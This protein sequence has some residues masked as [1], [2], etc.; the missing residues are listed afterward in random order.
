MRLK[1]RTLLKDKGRKPLP[2]ILLELIETAFVHRCIPLYYFTSFLYRKEVKNYLDYICDRESLQIHRA[3][4]RQD[5]LDILD[6][7]LL[8]HEHFSNKRIAMP[9]RLGYNL[10]KFWF[11][12]EASGT[13]DTEV[14]SADEFAALMRKLFKHSDCASIFAKPLR[15]GGGS[16]IV[17]ITK[18]ILAPVAT[19]DFNRLF[20]LIKEGCFIFQK[21]IIQHTGLSRV[22]NS[23]LNTIRIDTFL[24]ENNKPE[25]ISAYLRMGI[26]G[27]VVDNL[28]AGG[29]YVG[30]DLSSGKLHKIARNKIEMGGMVYNKHPDSG[31]EFEGF[32]I[33]YFTEVKTLACQ[34]ARQISERLVGWDIGIAANGPVLIE[35][36]GWYELTYVQIA[37]GGYRRHPVFKKAMRAAGL[38]ITD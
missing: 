22:C 10:K 6:N 5:T 15:G 23:S 11:S 27:S 14:R 31:V 16:G 33:P 1:T 24:D 9:I 28:G 12:D 7:K 3:Y 26:S 38:R 13:R 37:Y 18:D 29:I 17:R 21:H 30:I 32:T 25:V 35:G 2:Q 20:Q 19:A 36:N 4:H 8:F 34:A